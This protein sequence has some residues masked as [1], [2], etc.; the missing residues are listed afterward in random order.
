[1]IEQRRKTENY[2]IE[3]ATLEQTLKSST[4]AKAELEGRVSKLEVG[5]FLLPPLS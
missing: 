2:K 5:V 1:M 3:Y 4:A